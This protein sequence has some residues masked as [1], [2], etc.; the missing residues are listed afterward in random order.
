VLVG[1]NLVALSWRLSCHGLNFCR[2]SFKIFCTGGIVV[3]GWRRQVNAICCDKILS[4]MEK[5]STAGLMITFMP[6]M[7]RLHG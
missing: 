6:G 5:V 3:V 4:L 7:W 1:V 2:N